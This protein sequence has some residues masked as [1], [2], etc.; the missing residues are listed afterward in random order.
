MTRF[1]EKYRAV[2][3]ALA[4]VLA[5]FAVNSTCAYTLYQEEIPDQAKKLRKF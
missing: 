3:A 5:T 1:I 4:L 2:I